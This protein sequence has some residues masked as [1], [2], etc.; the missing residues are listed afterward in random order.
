MPATTRGGRPTGR[1]RSLS[2]V[3]PTGAKAAAC[4]GTWAVVCLLL[5][6]LLA[7]C[8]VERHIPEG[9]LYLKETTVA[10]TDRNATKNLYLS[11]YVLQQPNKKWFGFKVPVHIYA[12]SKPG[13]Q[14]GTSRLLRKLGEAPVIFDPRRADRTSENLRQVLMNAGYLHACVRQDRQ[15]SGRSLSLTYEVRPGQPYRIRSVRRQIDDP[16]LAIILCGADTAQSLLR[17]GMSFDINRL[18]EE[19]GRISTLLRGIG[20][21]QF[22]K[23]HISYQADTAA[24]SNLVALTVHVG[25]QRDDQQSAPRPHTQ[26]RIGQVR[27]LS[28]TGTDTLQLDS[29]THSGATIVYGG[30]RLRFRPS[31]LTSNTPIHTG[32]LFDESK[33]RRTYSNLMRLKAIAFSHV[34]FR[35]HGADTLDCEIVLQ[36]ARP[37]AVSLDLEGTNSN[38]DLGAAASASF[39]HKNLFKGS[40]T[41]TLKLR[42][43]YEAITGLDGYEGD[44]YTEL[45]G[46]LNLAFPNLLFPGVSRRYSSVHTGTSEISLQYNR[47]DRPEFR[48]RVLTAAWRYRWQ[49]RSHRA[50]H[51]FDLLE[52]NYIYMPWIS[53]RFKEQY[54]DS[55]GKENA[56]LRYNY[57]NLLISKIGYTYSFNSLG[58]A[59]TTTYGK[60]AYTLRFNVETAGNFM[61][62]ATRLVDPHYNEQHR[63]TFCGIVFA[64]YARADIDLTRSLRID[65]NNSVALHAA[66][67]VAVPYG[68][69]DQL[70]FEKRYFAGG[71]NS[72]RGWSVRSL[73]P[74]AYNGADR[75]INFLNQCGDIKL[76]LSVEYR[77]FLFWKLNGAAFIDAGN[78]WT[79]KKY[80]DQP[81]GEFRFDK[82]YEQIACSYGLGLRLALDFFTLRFDAG[83]KA[84]DPAHEG[85]RHWPVIHP[86][87]SRDFAFHFAVGLPF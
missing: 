3:L 34:A 36:H 37:Y 28:D 11:S 45:G 26:F 6:S 48:R 87:F 32:Q 5:S 9:S 79:I 86:V 80:D 81:G 56:I 31:L 65:R 52:L 21:Y 40:E 13:S 76:D 71:A 2:H 33:Q 72:V 83:M 43:A 84:I 44:S 61:N 14:Q 24:G 35:P 38:G 63:R 10:S 50:R 60:D 17:E 77:T 15:V 30:E 62:L 16:A 67:G 12:L 39:S 20:Y 51:R 66:L 59:A 58:N 27:F 82:F 69:S 42:G 85:R 25:L 68:N 47:Q 23:D 54:L 57:E 1:P 8:A 41:L 64:Q 19:R 18:N 7:S 75:Q 74:G 22:N 73:G 49:T 78:I 29:L 55:L 70:P 46:E 53:H 4:G